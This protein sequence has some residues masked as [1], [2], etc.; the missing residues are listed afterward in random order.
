MSLLGY[1]VDVRNR[2]AVALAQFSN[3]LL[4]FKI[5]FFYYVILANFFSR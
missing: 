4:R 2:F 1:E 3:T 5:Y